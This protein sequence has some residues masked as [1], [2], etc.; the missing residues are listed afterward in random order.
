M[1]LL[2]QPIG[3]GIG[4]W[5]YDRLLDELARRYGGTIL[6]KP[7]LHRFVFVVPDLIGCGTASNP[8]L[9]TDE[10]SSDV[11]K[12]PLLSVDDWSDQLMGLVSECESEQ[13][14]L[15]DELT[16]DVSWCILSN[17]G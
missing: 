16:G 10:E 14:R 2:I 13:M 3:V 5:Y 4:C 6:H 15:G 8:S 17:G 1:V 11:K 7:T 9:V 12:L